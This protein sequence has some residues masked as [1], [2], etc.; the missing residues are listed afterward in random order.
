MARSVPRYLIAAGKMELQR[1]TLVEKAKR[2]ARTEA[3]RRKPEVALL[4]GSAAW[5]TLSS[6]S[7]I[8]IVFV[9][10]E[11]GAVSYRYYLPGLTDVDIRTEVGRI[12]L[13]YLKQVLAAGYDDEISTGLREQI[14]NARVLLGN[15]EIEDSLVT[16]FASLKPRRRLLGEYLHHARE[17]LRRARSSI[18]YEDRVGFACAIDEFTKNLWR[19]VLVSTR[20]V[21]V[22]K[23]KHEIRAARRTLEAAQLDTYLRSRRI[24]GVRRKEA[25]GFLRASTRAISRTLESVGVDSTILG[26]SE[27]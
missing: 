8:D 15:R 12:P 16:D 4:T 9:V 24:A 3:D 23:D 5:G 20:R 1:K 25:G 6:R 17:A 21:G 11:P 19:L 18:T 10:S 27:V 14:A 26:D 13:P 22:Q 7:D 2:I